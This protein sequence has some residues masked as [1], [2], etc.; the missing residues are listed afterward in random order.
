[1]SE[2]EA[3]K[4]PRD[5]N[6]SQEFMNAI[7]QHVAQNPGLLLRIPQLVHIIAQQR[8]MSLPQGKF[9]VY[10]GDQT[11]I[12]DHA[13]PHNISQLGGDVASERP[14]TLVYPLVPISEIYRNAHNMKVLCIGPR[15]EAEIFHLMAYGFKETN[16]YG[17]DLISY[18]DFIT[19]GDMHKNPFPDS[20]FDVVI[21]GW[22]LAY[23]NDNALAVKESMR[24]L[25]PGGYCS[26]GCVREAHD[27]KHELE[28]SKAVGPVQVTSDWVG[29]PH[30]E[31]TVSR[32]YNLGQLKR[33][34]E[35][36]IEKIYFENEPIE[37]MEE[38]QDN[39]ILTFR[40]K[41]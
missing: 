33:L 35:P 6:I 1:M 38:L 11:S 22:V 23:S 34:F 36:Y 7:F 5:I 16:I 8:R 25:R 27:H 20:M 30:D 12:Q 21:M 10:D 32:Y 9:S 37:G 24:V 39:V 17:L 28:A 19:V 31:K 4:L 2:Q 41:L 15:S 18:S 29:G 40:K 14:L 26:V 3:V 13:L